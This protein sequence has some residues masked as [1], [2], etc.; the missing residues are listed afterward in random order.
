VLATER[1]SEMAL[2]LLEQAQASF[3]ALSALV[4]PELAS[5]REHLA[6][7]KVGWRE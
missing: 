5:V 2:V 3:P 4:W 1:V 6:Q 7:P